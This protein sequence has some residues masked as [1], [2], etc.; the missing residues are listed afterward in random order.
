[1]KK[2]YPIFFLFALFFSSCAAEKRHYRP[3]FYKERNVEIAIEQAAQKKHRAKSVKQPATTILDS[4]EADSS[5]RN[6]KLI[7]RFNRKMIV[8]TN[9]IV[10]SLDTGQQKVIREK[11]A[12]P[13]A[14]AATDEFQLND[15]AVSSLLLG[16][17]AVGGAL[18]LFH[19]WKNPETAWV[20]VLLVI[21]AP[22]FGIGAIIYGIAAMR[23]I[24]KA[25]EHKKESRRAKAGIML[26]F[27]ALLIIAAFISQFIK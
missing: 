14:S 12:L 27:I 18:F 10:E 15:Y 25:G 1:M 23:A 26:G 21:V 13:A 8:T 19:F 20:C 6:E 24:A 17:A 16:I 22:L 4:I 5:F 11:L 2:Y 3:G 7:V 9:T